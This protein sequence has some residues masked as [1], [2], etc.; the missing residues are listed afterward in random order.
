MDFAIIKRSIPDQE[1]TLPTYLTFCSLVPECETVASLDPFWKMF[2]R[3]EGNWVLP[4]F[5]H[6]IMILTIIRVNSS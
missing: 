6:I 1:T 2:C 3:G 4:N 5:L